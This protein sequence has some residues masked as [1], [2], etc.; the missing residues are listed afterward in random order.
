MM[1]SW[2]GSGAR[3]ARGLQRGSSTKG[4]RARRPSHARIEALEARPLLA[5]LSVG[6]LV[7]VTRMPGNQ[8]QPSIAVNP[9]DP[10]NLVV[11]GESVDHA[12]IA[13]SVSLDGGSS[14]SSQ[15]MADGTS[16]LPKAFGTA[17]DAFDSFGNLLI[18]Y[19]D[20]SL[21]SVDVVLS[22]DGGK[23][24]APLSTI[25]N[26]GTS[27]RLVVGPGGAA[28]PLSVWIEAQSLSDGNIV[29][30]GAPINGLGSVG[31]F[32]APEEVAGSG[33]SVIGM[34]SIGPKGQFIVTYE[35]PAGASGPGEIFNALDP[36]GLGAAPM[37]APVDVTAVNIGPNDPLPPQP[38]AT[39]STFGGLA[40][41]VS[42]QTHNGR[43]YLV[44]LDTQPVGNPNT[45]IFVEYSDDNGVTWSQD[46]EVDDAGG[47]ST[48]ILPKIAVDPTTGVVAVTWLDAR[49]DNGSGPDD[50]DGKSDDDVEEYGTV[51]VDGGASFLPNVKIARGPSNAIK[52]TGVVGPDDSG[53]DFG[54][55]TGLA[56]FD[57]TLY[58]AWP[59]N[60]PALA[61]NPDPSSFDI[62]T[63]NV[64]VVG[65]PQPAGALIPSAATITASEGQSFSGGV[66]T[67]T[68]GTLAPTPANYLASIDW[69]D[70]HVSSGTI[71]P[72]NT[73]GFQ[74]GGTHTYV[75]GGTYTVRVVALAVANSIPSVALST[76][77]V[78]DAPL[79]G[80]GLPVSS[81]EG[82]LFSGTLATFTDA[83]PNPT[84]ASDYSARID[85]GD[86]TTSFGTITVALRSSVPTFFVSGSH[87]LSA[88]Q[89][90]IKT[91]I[92]D[93][94]G[95]ET[96]VASPAVVADLALSGVGLSL[97]GSEGQP[98]ATPLA[99]FNDSDPRTNE[100]S[101]YTATVSWGDGTTSQGTIVHDPLGSGFD[102]DGS[103]PYNAGSY[104]TSIT[105]HDVGG[106]SV[107]VSGSV[108]IADVALSGRGKNITPS[109]GE[110]FTGFIARF[111]D[112]DP[113]SNPGSLYTASIDWG[114]GTT[115]SGTVI[116]DGQGGYLVR[117]SHAYAAGNFNTSITVIDHG[118]A[119]T[120]MS[121]TA[122]VVASPLS[123]TIATTPQVEEGVAFI[124]PIA[125]FT[126]AS[127]IAVATDFSA[128]IDWGDGTTSA[129]M[130]TA[131]SGGGFTVSGQQ[132]YSSVGTFS[133]SVTVSSRSGAQGDAGAPITVSDAPLAAIGHPVTLVDKTIGQA[134]TVATF[135]DANVRAD[136]GQFSAVVDWGDG[137]SSPG[138]VM[139][140]D[141][142]GGFDVVASHDYKESGSY[143]L[144]V[145][146]IDIGGAQVKAIG[147]ATVSDRIF[148]LSGGPIASAVTNNRQPSFSGTSE[149]G[150]TVQL[151]AQVAGQ[152]GVLPI[153]SGVANVFGQ[154][155]AT[156]VPL[157]DG[158]YFVF[159][160][161]TD[162]AG[163]P[164]SPVTQ[165]LPGPS[166]GPLVIDTAGPKVVSAS[167]DPRSGQ[168]TVLLQDN[169]SGF[170]PSTLGTPSAFAFDTIT[171]KGI[172]RI[173]FIGYSVT[174]TGPNMVRVSARFTTGS[175]PKAANY[176]LR[177]SAA[178]VTD[179]AG[180]PLDERLF[181]PFPGSGGKT[182]SDF[183]A[184]FTTNGR[185][186][187][188]PRQYVSAAERQGI[189]RLNKFIRD[190][191]R[192]R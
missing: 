71:I 144:V 65:G 23:T 58:P 50:T 171:A 174:A 121:G 176:L 148:A 123:V 97:T 39:A 78:S 73:G 109:E 93:L 2:F 185:S 142:A 168:L 75:E 143:P 26:I 57:N 182:G 187:A 177:I 88:G 129:G 85:W 30:T 116:P 108:V 113:R 31:T 49:N 173:P 79:T 101:N 18:S 191:T 170:G 162:A 149:P 68:G 120:E 99:V 9:T 167:V 44:K 19:L 4:E 72:N 150:S 59:D 128:T 74:V 152:S 104:A 107:S 132:A 54:S 1:P 77:T 134:V 136:L 3:R 163:R 178:A 172:V 29:A 100:A 36:D 12:G 15:F 69:G 20:D 105:I 147:A 141:P 37:N 62:A 135:S 22:T 165:L 94:G 67:F 33:S 127:P 42:G 139:P 64:T 48:Q 179:L 24:L 133:V 131:Q 151:F 66:A 158:S 6:Q 189:N 117:G 46:V 112:A 45:A 186:P 34:P 90:S 84:I 32:I 91:T 181:V 145:T 125:T 87:A 5:S 184:Q 111:T 86:G 155:A 52:A 38:V 183:L 95:A 28:A 41:D 164:S 192:S 92:D 115:T 140:E 70:G 156:T 146:I 13:E 103:H 25:K 8:A 76:A 122:D 83:D 102:V 11:V 118:G 106:A 21:N 7:N 61:N 14:W 175:R 55:Y 98:L 35:T 40:Y 130:I 17:T 89:F 160:S 159:A 60:S 153:G 188:G 51:S 119:T 10:L 16:S 126:S 154:W 80:S 161:A 96:V 137:T 169:L 53:F 110:P 190:H 180:N 138:T 166:A 124:A 27:P 81:T 63:A 43:V 82:S 114:D 56:F 157:P 47:N